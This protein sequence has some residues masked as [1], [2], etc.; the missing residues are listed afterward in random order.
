MLKPRL[1]EVTITLLYL[2][3]SL[4]FVAGTSLAL[5][6]KLVMGLHPPTLIEGSCPRPLI[7]HLDEEPQGPPEE[8]DR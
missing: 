4:A 5:Y 8:S 6:D 2:I 7:H 1:M 3:G